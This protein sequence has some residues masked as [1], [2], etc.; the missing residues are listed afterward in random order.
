MPSADSIESEE[1]GERA[2]LFEA[3]RTTATSLIPLRVKASDLGHGQ[4]AELIR[5]AWDALANAGKI[6]N[7][8]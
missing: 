5:V 8:K 4:A 1:D 3:L 6:V 7:Q 2:N